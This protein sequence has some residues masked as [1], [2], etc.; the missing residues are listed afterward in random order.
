MGRL[1]RLR[2]A[3]AAAGGGA[4]RAG[5]AGLEVGSSRSDFS[6]DAVLPAGW[7]HRFAQNSDWCGKHAVAWRDSRS[8]GLLGA[9]ANGTRRPRG[10]L[11]G[12]IDAEDGRRSAANRREARRDRQSR[13][14]GAELRE[15]RGR[16]PAQRLG[17]GS[18][19]DV[20]GRRGTG[21]GGSGR[22]FESPAFPSSLEVWTGPSSI[23][24]P[25]R[26]FVKSGSDTRAVTRGGEYRA[27]IGR[28]VVRLLT[29]ERPFD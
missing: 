15:E 1:P 7:R 25:A 8:E 4:R 19:R 22:A 11:E 24:N 21:R 23:V 9:V 12:P 2:R 16:K 3:A 6:T 5:P 17:D 20:R 27:A 29:T 10:A 13:S 14:T 26:R 18:R 28:T